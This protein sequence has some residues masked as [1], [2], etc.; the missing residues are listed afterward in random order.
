MVNGSLMGGRHDD[1]SCA[2]LQ[3]GLCYGVANARCSASDKNTLVEKGVV[4][5][6]IH[7]F[8]IL[9]TVKRGG[10]EWIEGMLDFATVLRHSSL[11]LWVAYAS[12]LYCC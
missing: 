6:L 12:L 1:M 11:G 7:V 4:L 5:A 9:T 10:S 8:D 3:G 2:T